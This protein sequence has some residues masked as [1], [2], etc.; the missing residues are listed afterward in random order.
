MKIATV[1]G[2][3]VSTLKNPEF[4]GYKL[5]LVTDTDL[6][7][8]LLGD[9]YIALDTVD[10]GQGDRVLINKEGGGAR[11]LLDNPRIPVQAVIVGVVD[12]WH[13]E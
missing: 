3:V 11:L 8:S 13:T 5:L 2:S 4:V 7:G 1:T 9:P 12:D 6:D 10:A